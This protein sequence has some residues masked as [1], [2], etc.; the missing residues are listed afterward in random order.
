VWDIRRFYKA[1]RS[2]TFC[3]TQLAQ[4][5]DTILVAVAAEEHAYAWILLQIIDNKLEQLLYLAS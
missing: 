3:S 5:S 1:T 4:H 2:N